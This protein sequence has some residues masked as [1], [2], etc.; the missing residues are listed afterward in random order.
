[1]PPQPRTTAPP[2][3]DT[4]DVARAAFVAGLVHSTL[5]T[6]GWTI[7]E[8]D[9]GE[10]R[11]TVGVAALFG[12]GVVADVTVTLRTGPGAAVSLEHPRARPVGGCPR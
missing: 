5:R 3:A 4:D 9:A 8:A 6:A 11:C 10:A 2:A 7:H 1:M 12:P